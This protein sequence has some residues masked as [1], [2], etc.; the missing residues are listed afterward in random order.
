VFVEWPKLRYHKVQRQLQECKDR[1]IYLPCGRQSGK[2]EL[3]LRRLVMYLPVKKPWPD[4]RYFYCGPTY[5]QAQNVAWERLIAL[6][7]EHWI[8]SISLSGLSI[9]TIFGSEVF[10]SGLDTPAR[11]EGRILDGGVIDENSDIKPGTFDLSIGPTLVIRKGWCWFIGV[12]KRFGVGAI[13]Y[14]DRYMQAAKGE[15]PETSAFTWPS[16]GIVSKEELDR[17]RASM[18]ARDFDEQFNASWISASGGVFHAF[19]SEYNVRPCIYNP[20]IPLIVTSDFNVDPMCWVMGHLR[21]ETFEVVDELHK[22]DTNTPEALSI[23][24]SRYANHTG[25]FQMYGDASAS[26]RRTSAYATDYNHIANNEELKAKGRTLHYMTKNP[27]RVDRFAITNARFCDAAGTR[28]VFIDEKCKNLIHD[29]EVRSYKPGTRETNDDGDTG[30]MT[31]ALGYFL[32]KKFPGGLRIT[33][34]NIVTIHRR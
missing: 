19:D 21:G 33:N 8:K 17:S 16:T 6:T 24:L 22:R 9:K 5:G 26:G 29:L 13:E 7:P 23:L 30:H 12:P 27:P 31:D 20:T 4:P 2:T 10:I 25:G 14:R 15:L 28:K 32:Y 1:F 11:I 3:A 34:K 18:D